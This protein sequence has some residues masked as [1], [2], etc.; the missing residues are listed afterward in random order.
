M[1]EKYIYYAITTEREKRFTAISY[2]LCTEMISFEL[3]RF[4]F[5]LFLL[6]IITQYTVNFYNAKDK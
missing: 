3:H 1:R 4:N 6:T 2:V 5:P